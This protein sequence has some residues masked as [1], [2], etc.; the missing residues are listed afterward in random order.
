MNTGSSHNDQIEQTHERK[1]DNPIYGDGET[2]DGVCTTPPQDQQ[3]QGP[4]QDHEFDNPIYG[5]DTDD[6][7]HTLCYLIN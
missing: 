7:T 6:Q 5:A 1:F 4:V 2:D 3:G